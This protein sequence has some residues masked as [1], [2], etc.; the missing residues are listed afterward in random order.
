MHMHKRNTEGTENCAE[1]SAFLQSATGIFVVMG[2]SSYLPTQRQAQL[3]SSRRERSYRAI[4]AGL[5]LWNLYLQ[6]SAHS[7]FVQS[8]LGAGNAFSSK[9]SAENVDSLP[10]TD[11][12]S[13]EII[14][15]G[16]A[17]TVCSG[18]T[19]SGDTDPGNASISAAAGALNASAAGSAAMSNS[20]IN[21]NHT[22]PSPDVSMPL[23]AAPPPPPSPAPVATGP[24]AALAKLPSYRLDE[25]GTCTSDFKGDSKTAMCS[26]F[27]AE[28]FSKSHCVYA[29]RSARPTTPCALLTIP[30]ERK[31]LLQCS[32]LRR[33]PRLV[34]RQPRA[35]R[36]VPRMIFLS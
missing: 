19:N 21:L 11:P 10:F 29:L 8:T 7:S 24:L 32:C 36:V 26:S 20:S 35:S 23:D 22:M 27:C 18:C 5:L 12:A 2:S 16:A 28:K 1:G 4:I 9:R 34:Y 33:D 17:A 3:L 14:P 30:E 15:Y 25:G 6:W 13:N 31:G